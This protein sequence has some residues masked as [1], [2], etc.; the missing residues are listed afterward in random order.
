MLRR[1]S[2]RPLLAEIPVRQ[3]APSRPA[4]LGRAELQAFSGL[5][6]ELSGSSS[7]LA[8]G[9][10]R[11]TVA[12][13]L[14]A[15][16]VAQGRRVA[17]LE[18]DLATPALALTLGLDATPGLHEY[19]LGETGA[20]HLLQPLTLAGPASGGASEPLVC[21]VAGAPE[22][23]PVALLDS[24]RC[25]QAIQKLRRAYD[26]LAIVGPP[27]EKDAETLLAL[28]EHA[29]TT[30]ACGGQAE[31]RKRLPPPVTGRVVVA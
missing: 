12:L 2:K 16:A 24:D 30:I 7:V 4:A 5:A 13:G 25:D 19:L 28:A 3:D 1:G 15:A 22:P 26:L 18:C 17:L 11:S 20:A 27:L 31:L 14:A 9:P 21:I 23:A 29:D 6:R 10:A 8:T